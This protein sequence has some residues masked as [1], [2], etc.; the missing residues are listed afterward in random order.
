MWDNGGHEDEGLAQ[1][2]PASGRANAALVAA[3]SSERMDVLAAAAAQGDAGALGALTSACRPS[4][5]AYAFAR[6]GA[7][8]DAEDAVQEALARACKAIRRFRPG[9]RWAPWFGR[10]LQNVCSDAAR[11]RH[12]LA[13]APLEFSC[14]DAA[15]GPEA[16]LLEREAREALA[17]ALADLPEA[18]RTPVVMHYVLGRPRQEIADTLGLP[19]S[20]VVG[21]LASALRRLRRRSGVA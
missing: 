15:A 1:A 12:S 18:L 20:T 16:S 6:L 9:A 21:R 5:I 17:R 8:D 2:D 19:E 7:R 13:T 11:R 4:A 3:P 10:I 14:R